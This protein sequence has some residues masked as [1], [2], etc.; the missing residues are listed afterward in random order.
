MICTY[1]ITDIFLPG[2]DNFFTLFDKR[3]KD[4]FWVTFGKYMAL[5]HSVTGEKVNWIN[6]KTGVK[7]VRFRLE[8][9]EKSA[10]IYIE[11]SNADLDLQIK[12]FNQLVNVDMPLLTQYTDAGWQSELH[13]QMADGRIVSRV[14]QEHYGV[15]VYFKSDWPAIISFLKS[16]LTG[17]DR[18]WAEQKDIYALIEGSGGKSF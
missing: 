10:G 15:N 4:E 6:Y 11:F 8:A 7:Q 16:K 9:D 18:F 13:R 1:R 3:I 12:L 14:L 2:H 5:H 17:I